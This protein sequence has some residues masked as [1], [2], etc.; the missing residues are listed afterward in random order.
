LENSTILIEKEKM[1]AIVGVLLHNVI[2]ASE[3]DEFYKE[4]E[5]LERNVIDGK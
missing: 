3:L 2:S 5:W 1:V 4:V